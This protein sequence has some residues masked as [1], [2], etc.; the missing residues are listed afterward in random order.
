VKLLTKKISKGFKK[1][2]IKILIWSVALY[3]CETWTMKKEV[4]NGLN[5]FEMWVWR[6]IE[7][8]SWTDK[9]SNEKVLKIVDDKRRFVRLKQ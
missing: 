3:G 6:R 5:G 2:M 9:K 4:I 1:R 8:I 7:K